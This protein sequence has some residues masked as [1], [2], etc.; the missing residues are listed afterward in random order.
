[1]VGA[2]QRSIRGS[3][4]LETLLA[5]GILGLAAPWVYD[6]IA[7]TTQ[8]LAE[9]SAA[10]RFTTL[11][12][13]I[14]NFMLLN[15]SVWPDEYEY[16]IAADDFFATFEAYGATRP[17]ASHPDIFNAPQVHITKKQ[18]A[19]GVFAINAYMTT[20]MT[21]SAQMTAARFA[22]HIGAGAMVN[23]DGAVQV[24]VSA[25]GNDLDRDGFLHRV[26]V[27]GSPELNAMDTNLLMSSGG[28]RFGIVGVRLADGVEIDASDATAPHLSADTF[29]S[30]SVLFAKGLRLNPEKSFVKTLRVAGDIV[31]VKT[32]T[33]AAL[34]GG[35]PG[36]GMSTLSENTFS[37]QGRVV[38]DRTTITE[39]L[40]VGNTLSI[41][42]F[43]ARTISAFDE[44]AANSLSTPT[45]SVAALN[46]GGGGGVTISSDRMM[47]TMMPPIKLGNWSFPGN[48]PEFHVIRVM[49]YSSD[50]LTELLTAEHIDMSKLMN[51]N[52]QVAE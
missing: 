32:M 52:W 7:Q 5:I 45:I 38:A 27:A 12:D 9:V 36:S 13:A 51:S 30:V 28:Q 29:D 3:S 26:P 33:A 18:T 50:E 10:R 24:R 40:L 22:R 6:R 11:A 41:K 39:E 49:A 46:V 47:D 31:G 15:Q 48:T 8:E 16:K 17:R 4:L 23:E 1:V 20:T 43:S 34:H 35:L 25:T 2:Y 37:S 21:G 14:R 42:P 19:L 44:V